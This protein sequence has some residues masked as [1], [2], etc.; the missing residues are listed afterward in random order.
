[1]PVTL[2]RANDLRGS[3]WLLL[4]VHDPAAHTFRRPIFLRNIFHH[5]AKHL[6]QRPA[7]AIFRHIQRLV[8]VARLAARQRRDRAADRFVTLREG[9]RHLLGGRFE[10]IR[11]R[12]ARNIARVRLIRLGQ[13][14]LAAETL[15]GLR[16]LQTGIQADALVEDETFA[17]VMRA[18]TFLE[19]FQDA[20]VELENIFETF[21]LHERSGLLAPDAARAEHHD[22]LLFHGGWQLA[23]GVGKIPEMI[24]AN[25]QRVLERAELHLVI[26]ARVQQRHRAPFVQPLLQLLRREFW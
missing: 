6:D 1:M 15:R 7:V 26:I 8:I 21:A 2:A 12:L 20:A 4:Q 25:R 14:R 23:D 22:G 16:L 24:H 11:T 19:I 10:T 13:R 9:Q 5:A 18:A 17:V 3:D